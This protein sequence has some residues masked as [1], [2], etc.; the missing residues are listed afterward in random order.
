MYKYKTKL[1]SSYH[2]VIH[3]TA[4][5]WDMPVF[6]C[7]FKAL[8]ERKKEKKKTKTLELCSTDFSVSPKHL[9]L[10]FDSSFESQEWVFSS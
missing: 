2:W 4:L 8:K 3:E 10:V 5:V 7:C 9:E 6:S 1:R